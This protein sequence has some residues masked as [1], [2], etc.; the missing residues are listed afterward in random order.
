MN[1]P[2]RIGRGAQQ[3]SMQT[4]S[5]KESRNERRP[6]QCED[7]GL[8]VALHSIAQSSPEGKRRTQST[9]VPLPE[10]EEVL[11]HRELNLPAK[12]FHVSWI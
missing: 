6:L 8:R 12:S 4:E 5:G 2:S 9:S 11:S 7:A 10:K 1:D 3:A